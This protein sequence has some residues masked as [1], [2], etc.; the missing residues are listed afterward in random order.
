M[1]LYRKN[2]GRVQQAVRV[3]VG[4]CIVALAALYLTGPLAWVVAISGTVFACS[5]LFGYC[6]MCAAAGIGTKH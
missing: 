3:A 4:A 6:P 2:M 5:G 1:T